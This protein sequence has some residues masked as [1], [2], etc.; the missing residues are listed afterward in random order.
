MASLDVLP[1]APL[2]V[3]GLLFGG[4]VEHAESEG[5]Y[6]LTVFARCVRVL[7]VPYL[8]R[9]PRFLSIRTG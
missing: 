7:S 8:R 4:Q 1:P 2:S 5:M 3:F 9:C 6:F